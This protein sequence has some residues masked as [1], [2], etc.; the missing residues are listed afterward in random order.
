[1]KK[2][3]QNY[4]TAA[5][6]KISRDEEI[7]EECKKFAFVM[8]ILSRRDSVVVRSDD[9]VAFEGMPPGEK[10]AAM[11]AREKGH[12]NPSQIQRRMTHRHSSTKIW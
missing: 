3:N 5:I 7:P 8:A 1:M 10:C 2:F 12:L 4:C 6:A 9:A 11:H